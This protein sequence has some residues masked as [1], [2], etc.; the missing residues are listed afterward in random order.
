MKPN[1]WTAVSLLWMTLGAMAAPASPPASAPAAASPAAS[2]ARRGHEPH[3]KA[4]GS[5]CHQQ[6]D[7]KRLQGSQRRDFLRE[8]RRHGR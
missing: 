1:N 3:M 4:G 6:A 8:C 2:G 7:D 5:H